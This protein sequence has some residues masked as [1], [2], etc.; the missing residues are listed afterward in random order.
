MEDNQQTL[1]R[2]FSFSDTNSTRKVFSLT[3][4]IRAVAGGT[5]ASK[6]ISI[7]VWIIDYCQTKQGKDKLVSVVSESHPHLEKGAILDFEN[8][9]KDRGY[10]NQDRWNQT[11]HT[12]T[13]ET[14]N[15]VEFYSVDTYGK[16]HGP[17]RDVLFVNECNNLE[18]KI[19][20]Q[21][22]TRTREI[23]WLDW[24]PSEEFWF[25]TEMQPNRDDI[26]FITLTY[27]DNDA[28]DE[29]TIREI[30][31]HINNKNWWT[32]YGLGQLGAIESRIYTKW[33]IIDEIPFEAK[34]VRYWLDFG[35]SNDPTS[36]GEIY[37]YNGGYI[38]NEVT[39][40]K[41][42]LNKQIADI[43]NNRDKALV[44]ADSSEPKS[45]DE[46]HSYGVMII[47]A[48]KG[49]DSIKNGIQ[50]V[51]NQRISVTSRS[52]NVIKEYRNYLWMT[53]KSGTIINTP[54]GGFDHCFA[55][56]T[57]I[58]TTKGKRKIHELV[59]KNGKLYSRNG[60]IEK[61]SN[62]RATRRNTEMLNITFDDG[63]VLSVT[64]DHLLL[65]PDGTWIESS[66]INPMDMIQ[67]ATY[68]SDTDISRKR[69]QIISKREI[70]QLWTKKITQNCLEFLQWNDRKKLPYSP[71]R[72]E[73]IQQF[74]RKFGIEAQI[75]SSKG[76]FDPRTPCKTKDMGRKDTAYDCEMAQIRSGEGLA[77]IT[78]KKNLPKERTNFEKLCSLPQKLFKFAICRKRKILP[79]ELQ[80]EGKTKTVVGIT[81]GFSSLTYNLDVKN[82]HCLWANG[83]IAH[84]CMDGIRYG[85]TSILKSGN[86]TPVVHYGGQR[87]YGGNKVSTNK[88]KL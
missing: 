17:R 88:F 13:F 83:V 72:R 76:S 87:P 10:W 65:K 39:Y 41:G 55:A 35:Y 21:L 50:T 69:I 84:N 67:S 19:V 1:K 57:L 43:L 27:K 7:L 60:T 86:N 51:Q 47:G 54:D 26:D 30:E 56:D 49:P 38:L 63:N 61:F 53:D 40:Q 6:T 75:S 15:K 44:V 11:K 64:P 23:V 5:S 79:S 24:N 14:G 22:I 45:I 70:F 52:I 42:L 68:V 82:T 4:R 25:Y 34:L 32:V 31:S 62:V 80:N 58:Y 46:I 36:I 9:M 74:N 28:L 3:K 8:L 12:Y 66:L 18:Y 81:R 20:D 48:E 37:E 85:I 78:W 33:Q 71:Q 2:K 77:F 59:G 29:V 16:A 73:H